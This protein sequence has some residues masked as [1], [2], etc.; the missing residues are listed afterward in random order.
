MLDKQLRALLKYFWA[1]TAQP[2]PRVLGP[3]ILMISDTWCTADNKQVFLSERVS[4]VLHPAQ[5]N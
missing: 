3:N 1:K 4:R 2:P 5:Q